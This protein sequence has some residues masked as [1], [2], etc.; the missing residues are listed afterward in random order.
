MAARFI[1][2]TAA[3]EGVFHHFAV[4]HRVEP[5]IITTDLFWGHPQLCVVDD[6]AIGDHL[7]DMTAVGL[8]WGVDI[9]KEALAVERQE[10][11]GTVDG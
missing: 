3:G 8:V 4:G 11:V 7:A 10:Q 5:D 9:T 2:D 1:F 6:A